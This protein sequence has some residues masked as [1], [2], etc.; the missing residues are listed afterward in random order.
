MKELIDVRLKAMAAERGTAR[1]LASLAGV[2]PSTV[3]RILQRGSGHARVH[4]LRR[5][6]DAISQLEAERS[7]Q[8]VQGLVNGCSTVV[9]GEADK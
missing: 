3:S 5:I 6:E 4:V 1:R 8:A 7:D 9:G 2:A